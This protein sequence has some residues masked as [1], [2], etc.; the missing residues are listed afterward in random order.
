MCPA[1]TYL[2]PFE[3]VANQ[4]VRREMVRKQVRVNLL[5][6]NLRWDPSGLDRARALARASAEQLLAEGW[7]LV[8]G[9]DESGTF[10]QGRT[11]AGPIVQSALLVVQR[12]A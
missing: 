10:V 6:Y 5:P 11:L 9:V 8:A 2:L 12:A 3:Q 4:P 7:E 1:C